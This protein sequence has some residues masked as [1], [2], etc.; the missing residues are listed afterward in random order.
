ML[1]VYAEKKQIQ[2]ERR[3]SYF[4]RMIENDIMEETYE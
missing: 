2:K 1:V 3:Y 4:C